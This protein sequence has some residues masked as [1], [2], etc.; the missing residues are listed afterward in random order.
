MEG[1]LDDIW[2]RLGDAGRVL[3][4]GG[5]V[6]AP[7]ARRDFRGSF[8]ALTAILATAAVSKAVKAF[9]HEPRPNGDDSNS[10]PSQ[11]AAECFAAAVSLDRQFKDAIGPGAIGL[12][13]AVSLTRVFGRKH[14]PQDVIAGA[15]MGIA[16]GSLAARL[17]AE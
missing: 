17:P 16:A 13:A 14:H 12:A 3:L 2:C 8:N 5:A 15:G 4:V 9:W 1:E 10:F 7:L 11:H 6:V